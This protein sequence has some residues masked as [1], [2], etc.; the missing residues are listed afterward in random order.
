MYF[1]SSLF[2]Y[3][4]ASLLFLLLLINLNKAGVLQTLYIIHTA[5]ERRSKRYIHTVQSERGDKSR[6]VDESDRDEIKIIMTE[7]NPA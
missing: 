7:I 4:H 2:V 3:F 5:R 1:F 6:R